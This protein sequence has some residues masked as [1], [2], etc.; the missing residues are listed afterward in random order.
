MSERR[1]FESSTVKDFRKFEN[2]K[3]FVLLVLVYGSNRWFSFF[4]RLLFDETEVSS[5]LRNH[6]S[7]HIPRLPD[8]S[9]LDGAWHGYAN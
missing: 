3:G 6:A 1:K 9:Y 4:R 5:R 2:Q 8:A 7:G